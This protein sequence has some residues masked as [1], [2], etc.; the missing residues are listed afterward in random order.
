MS[1]KFCGFRIG[2]KVHMR[3]ALMPGKIMRGVVEKWQASC[4]HLVTWNE[5]SD[6]PEGPFKPFPIAIATPTYE[7]NMR[8]KNTNIVLITETLPKDPRC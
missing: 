5:I 1:C 3:S 8:E 6:S 2:D 7:P 4:G